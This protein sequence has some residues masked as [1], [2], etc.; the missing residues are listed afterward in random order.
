MVLLYSQKKWY[1]PVSEHNLLFHSGHRERLRQKF[2]DDK[3]AE[4][5]KLE[6][7]LTYVIPRRDVRPLAHALLKHFGSI[8]Q[9]LTASIEELQT[10]PGVGRNMSI[11]L[12]LIHQIVLDG[13]RGCMDSNPIFYDTNVLKNY[14]KWSLANKQIEEFHVLYLDADY[15]LI[16]D[17]KHSSGTF[18]FTNVYARE[19]IK[20]ALQLNARAI[21]LV[22]NHPISSNSFSTQDVE[23]TEELEKIFTSLDIKLYDHILVSKY[24]IYSG[25][26]YGFVHS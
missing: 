13:Y 8:S 22:H 2:L 14:C 6:L 1:S 24:S 20:A 12:K 23:T 7:M 26:D 19:I 3:L 17:D 11:F 21:V 10:I 16:K 15:R 4:Y 25:R 18:N 5:E 9:I